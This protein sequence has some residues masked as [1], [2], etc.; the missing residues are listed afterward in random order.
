MNV[1][2]IEKFSLYVSRNGILIPTE[3]VENRGQLRD[4]EICYQVK[5]L[6][7]E[8]TGYTYIYTLYRENFSTEGAYNI[9][10]YSKDTA[11]NEVSSTLE[12]K[13]AGI[14]FFIDDTAPQAVFDGIESGG[15]YDVSR[16]Q[17]NVL[18]TDNTRLEEAKLHL[19][20]DKGEE[21]NSWDYMEQTLQTQPLTVEIK[22]YAGGQVLSYSAVDAAGNELRVDM[23][24][25]ITTNP[26]IRL[27]RSLPIAKILTVLAAGG[28]GLGGVIWYRFRRRR[29]Y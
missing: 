22:E 11:G 20:N 23:D 2:R 27:T 19:T 7:N 14:S 3:L 15:I 29:R 8:Q 26:W 25:V 16:R 18:F 13:E 28:F 5:E 9:V 12:D 4:G 1:D 6:G 21:I 24:F 17:V 10:F